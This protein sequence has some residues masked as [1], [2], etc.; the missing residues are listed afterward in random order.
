MKNYIKKLQKY[1]DG[2]KNTLLSI[3]ELRLDIKDK[4]AIGQ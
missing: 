3:K 1:P 4:K 2:K